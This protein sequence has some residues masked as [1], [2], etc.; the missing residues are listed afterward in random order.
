MQ[1]PRKNWNKLGRNRLP[2]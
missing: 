2:G 1:N